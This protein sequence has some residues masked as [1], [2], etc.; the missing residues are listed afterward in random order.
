MTAMLTPLLQGSKI[1]LIPDPRDYY[2]VIPR[3]SIT[4]IYKLA[5]RIIDS[6][7]MLNI[8]YFFYDKILN[9]REI[10]ESNANVKIVLS[11]LDMRLKLNFYV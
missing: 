10:V 9:G 4:K 8:Y 1:I 2:A 3:N 5:N 6:C 11:N 7:H